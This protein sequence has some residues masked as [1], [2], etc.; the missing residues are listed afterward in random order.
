MGDDKPVDVTHGSA[1]N[2]ESS[3]VHSAKFWVA[4]ENVVLFGS[5]V[6]S[7]WIKPSRL[8]NL[9]CPPPKKCNLKTGAPPGLYNK[10]FGLDMINQPPVLKSYFF[11][12]KL[13]YFQFFFVSHHVSSISYP[14][15][16][17]NEISSNPMEFYEH[18]IDFYRFKAIS[19]IS[20]FRGRVLRGDTRKDL[21]RSIWPCWGGLLIRWW[22]SYCRPKNKSQLIVQCGCYMLLL[23]PLAVPSGKLT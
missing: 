18:L 15:N 14:W 21:T 2:T 19:K 7:R 8:N 1:D 5:N 3:T 11:L 9:H 22:H 4:R 10:L 13:I 16:F 12:S 17:C 20:W 23:K 6:K